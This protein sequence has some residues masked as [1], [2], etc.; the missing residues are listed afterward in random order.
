MQAAKV[1]IYFCE[2]FHCDPKGSVNQFLLI[3]W[4]YCDKYGEFVVNVL[5]KKGPIL[6]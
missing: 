6:A 4:Q 2:M 3:L 5:K 1:A